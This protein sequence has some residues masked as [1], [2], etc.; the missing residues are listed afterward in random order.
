MNVAI[1]AKVCVIL[2][3]VLEVQSSEKRQ[4]DSCS[5]PE[6]YFSSYCWNVVTNVTGS[7]D[8][9]ASEEI[10]CT[11]CKQDFIEYYRECVDAETAEQVDELCISLGYP[12]PTTPPTTPPPIT[13][14]CSD[15]E[16]Y[17]SSYCWNVITNI[18]SY[19]YDTLVEM[20][21]TDCRQDF[22]EYY[23]ECIDAERAELWD[24]QCTSLGYPTPPPT[25]PM[26]PQT[27][28]PPTP[29]TTPPTPSSGVSLG[30]VIGGVVGG[31]VGLIA[32]IFVVIL[33][34]FCCCYFLNKTTQSSVPPAQRSTQTSSAGT[35]PTVVAPVVGYTTTA[36]YPTADPVQGGY[37]TAP[38]Q[39]GYPTA[40]V[41]GGYPT[42]PVQGGY[43]TAP[44]QGGYPEGYPA[45]VYYAPMGYYVPC[46][47]STADNTFLPPYESGKGYPLDDGTSV[48]ANPN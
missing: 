35:H 22:I 28:P 33:C 14:S 10:L 43:P 13:D 40:P 18:N 1:A 23:R 11:D 45:A 48:P 9:D 2:C 26:I 25:P 6:S 3:L 19:D 5:D 42:A 4:S 36:P 46:T 31:V 24:E 21:C 39:G 20:L 41:Q 34:C 8:F 15:V 30:A 37:P 7:Y 44:V 29:P 32:L 12:P 16:S 27:T 17:I 38:V 47:T